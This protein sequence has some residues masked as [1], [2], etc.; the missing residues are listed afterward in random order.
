[1]TDDPLKARHAADAYNEAFL[2][3]YYAAHEPA[4]RASGDPVRIKLL[5]HWLMKYGR[6][7][8]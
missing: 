5:E 2:R 6:I 3:R 7:A 4:I 8:A 1:M